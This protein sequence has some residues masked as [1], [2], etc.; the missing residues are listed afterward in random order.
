MSVS[1]PSEL[2]C[3]GCGYG[4]VVRDEPPARCPMCGESRWRGR[5]GNEHVCAVAG[6]SAPATRVVLEAA[7]D[8]LSG[9]PILR[10]SERRPYLCSEHAEESTTVGRLAKAPVDGTPRAGSPAALLALLP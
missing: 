3:A 7:V 1:A 6:C 5:S 4:I 10:R 8:P 2:R 9:E